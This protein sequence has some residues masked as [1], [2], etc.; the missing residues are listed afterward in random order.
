M[1]PVSDPTTAARIEVFRTGTF[2]PMSGVPITYT[3]ADL[4]AVADAYDPETA[5]A[6]IVVG[7]PVADAPAFGWVESFDFDATADR[8]Y[9]NVGEIDP[10]FSAAVKAGR[11][12]KVSMSFFPPDQDA[13]PTPGS[14]Y[15]KHIGFLGGA[16]PAV[17]GLANV[18]FSDTAENAVTFVAEF[19]ERGFEEAASLFQS[20]RE[21]FIEKFGMEDADKALSSYRIEWLGDMEITQNARSAF[22]IPPNPSVPPKKETT[23][24]DP[25]DNPAFAARETDLAT[26]ETA[27]SKREA[28]I[29][30]DDNVSFAEAL[31]S[32]GKLLPA[33]KDQVVAVLD[34]LPSDATVAFA[35][36]EAKIAPGAA[37]RSILTA[38]PKTVEFGRTDLPETASGD[39]AAFA[40]D[41]KQVDAGQ[42]ELHAK[43]TTFQNQNPGTA[44]LDAVA[45]VS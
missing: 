19:G 42:M 45:A 2:T 39:A 5:P 9:A 23:T 11:Y 14:W 25:N 40:S 41:G 34:A 6:P 18:K 33:S 30:H 43:A 20:L 28:K 29:A 7:H 8:L 22:A 12:K 24:V 1:P 44:W 26:R 32:D 31:V 38:Q 17:S 4:K 35:E 16:A 15:P 37:L 10:T 27:I 36:G 21:F 3:A 13:N